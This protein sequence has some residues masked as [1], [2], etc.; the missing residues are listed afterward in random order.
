[1]IM[2]GSESKVQTSQCPIKPKKVLDVNSQSQESLELDESPGLGEGMLEQQHLENV[3]N[4]E[5]AD[6]SM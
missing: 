4:V 2:K 3:V 1:M 5:N 6:D